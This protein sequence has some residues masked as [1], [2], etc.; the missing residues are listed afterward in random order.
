METLIRR[1]TPGVNVFGSQLDL[2][3]VRMHVNHVF[4]EFAMTCNYL[5]GEYCCV[6]YVLSVFKGLLSA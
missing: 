5:T 6:Y 1:S 4:T 2:F 3:F